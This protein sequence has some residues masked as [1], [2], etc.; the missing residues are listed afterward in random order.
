MI[1]FADDILGQ[2]PDR[3]P[4]HSKRYR[5]FKTEYDRLQRERIAAFGEFKHDVTTGVYPGPTHT[6]GI[7]D[8]ELG[9]FLESLDA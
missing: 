8:G 6:I 5:D 4:R 2:N 9:R 7:D 3:Y 1:T